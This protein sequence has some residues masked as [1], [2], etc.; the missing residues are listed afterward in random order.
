ML[1]WGLLAVL[2]LAGPAWAGEVPDAAWVA[3]Y[4]LHDQQGDHTLTVVRD[5][6]RVEYRTP[7]E[8]V[9]VWEKV[10]DG[11]V[12]RQV[13]PTEGQVVVFAPG[14]LRA[15]GR[16]G[17]WTTLSGL[18][19][20]ALRGQ[21]HAVGNS[22]VA[23]ESATRYRGERKGTP[24]ELTWLAAASLPAHF[25]SGQGKS[26]F[27]VTLVTLERHPSAEA[28]TSTANYRELDAA[29]IGDMELDPFARRYIL[30]G[31]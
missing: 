9:R 10:G 24:I 30:E 22:K 29:D 18:V 11:L 25:R 17:D 16:G 31:F 21:L 5:D 28:F 20:P 3:H 7:D 13:F 19:D 14:D 27:E 1:R 6:T 12:H 15:S 8:P 4:R 26:R 2:S 23:G